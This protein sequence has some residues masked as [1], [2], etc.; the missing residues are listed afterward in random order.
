M[1][2]PTPRV[3]S[4][5]PDIAVELLTELGKYREARQIILGGGVALNHYIDSRPT[6]DLD[7]WWAAGIDAAA[8]A[9]VDAIAQGIAERR[10]YTLE[11]RRFGDV[12]SLD[13]VDPETKQK[14]FA[15]QIATRD[16]Q[17]EPPQQ[18]PWG[19][20]PI[21]RLRDN[22]ASK[23]TA[24]VARGAPRDFVDVKAAVDEKM[25]TIAELWDLWLAKNAERDLRQARMHVLHHLEGIERR[26][27]LRE[28][29]DTTER[30]RLHIAR[31][32]YRTAL[33]AGVSIA[34]P[35]L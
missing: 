22:L 8:F 34:E 7:A 10:S 19:F 28:I 12:A 35:R 29:E 20:L 15:F 25:A 6:V 24:L 13:F 11:R 16:A 27:P 9:R 31:L 30:E 3:P 14:V 1:Q 21:E 32:W 2:D 18:S 17:L 23:M 5:L 4:N 33:L 26:V